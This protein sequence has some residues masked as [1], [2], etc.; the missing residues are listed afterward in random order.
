MRRRPTTSERIPCVYVSRPAAKTQAAKAGPQG[1]F[2]LDFFG[3]MVD[4]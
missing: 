3:L 2:I 1:L 4:T